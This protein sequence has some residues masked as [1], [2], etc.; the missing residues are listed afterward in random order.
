[1]YDIGVHCRRRPAL[2]ELEVRRV[3]IE[4]SGLVAHLAVVDTGPGTR[5][6]PRGVKALS[7][8]TVQVFI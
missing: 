5:G 4:K 2:Q 7:I 6:K 8:V 1:M 3:C